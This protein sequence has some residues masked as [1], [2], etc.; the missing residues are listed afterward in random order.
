MQKTLITLL[1]VLALVGLPTWSQAQ[2]AITTTTITEPVTVT[3]PTTLTVASATGITAGIWLLIDNELVRVAQSYV[4]GTAVPVLRGPLPTTHADNEQVW[5][6]PQAATAT[7]AP[8]GSCTR[9]GTGAIYTFT[10]LNDGRIATCREQRGF[11]GVTGSTSWIVS[12][13]NGADGV[14]SKNPPTTQ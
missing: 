14:P 9:G 1:T 4:S 5:V 11:G 2:T 3:T 7:R 8:A 10:F 12:S 6:V 13:A